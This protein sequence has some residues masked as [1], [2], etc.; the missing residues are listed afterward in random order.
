MLIWCIPDLS[1]RRLFFAFPEAYNTQQ[2]KTEEN[3]SLKGKKKKMTE[4]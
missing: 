3:K 4:R 2:A 1:S